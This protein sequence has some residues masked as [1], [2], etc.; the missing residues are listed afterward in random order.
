MKAT[1]TKRPGLLGVALLAAATQLCTHGCAPKNPPKPTGWKTTATDWVGHAGEIALA[2]HSGGLFYAYDTLAYPGESVDL[3]ARVV[4]VKKL[5][6]VKGASVEFLLGEQSLGKADTDKEGM[7]KISW[8][9][10]QAGDYHITAKITAVEDDEFEKLLEIE[11]TPLLVAAR[12]KD[13]RFV[14]IDLDHTVVA[15][16][17]FR[18]LFAQAEPMPDAADMIA[19][20]RKDYSIV[21]LTHRPHLL[22]IKSKSWLADNG[23]AAG[24]LLVSTLTQAIGDSGKFKTD[25]L[26]SLRQ[27]FP[28]VA[29]GIGDKLSDTKAYVD[30]GLGAYLIPNYDRDGDDE[31]DLRKLAGQI[32][33][34]DKKVQVVDSWD[35]IRAGIYA[36]KKFAPGSYADRLEA[37]ADQIK[38]EKKRTRQEQQRREHDDDDDDDDDD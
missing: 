23:F 24:P 34:L 38:A 20:L 17:F 28:G 9:P 25:R 13:T 22:T 31:K 16:G 18:V 14:V 32:R 3:I 35:E 29:I 33:R 11:P 12:T 10:P 26:K 2:A 37:R 27:Q 4:S 1:S 21:Y 7:A 30:N 8:T 15:S 19:Q 5:G 36:G 6:Y